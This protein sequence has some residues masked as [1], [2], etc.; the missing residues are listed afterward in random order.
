MIAKLF[1]VKETANKG[2]GLFAKEFI[3]KGTIPCFECDKCKVVSASEI[4]YGKMSEKEK[5][6]L[7]DYAYRKEDGTFVLPC[8]ETRYLNHSCNANILGTEFG[9]D[10]VVRDIEKGEE[11]TY[12]YRDFYEDVRLSC[13]CG[14]PNCCKVL[15]FEHPLSE[16]LKQSWAKKIKAALRLVNKVKQPLK[17]ELKQKSI[18]LPLDDKWISG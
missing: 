16:E 6:A 2:K 5:M 9:F 4:G 15:T 17:D 18:F 7:L 13:G 11:A 1:E 14:E 10:I 12:D 3:P 8:D